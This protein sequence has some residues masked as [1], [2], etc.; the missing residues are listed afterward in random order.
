MV[1][2]QGM[3]NVDVMLRRHCEALCKVTTL[4]RCHQVDNILPQRCYNIASRC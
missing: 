1:A 2:F 3:S 4:L